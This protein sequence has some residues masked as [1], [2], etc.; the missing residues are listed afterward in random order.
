[1]NEDEQILLLASKENESEKQDMWYMDTGASNHMCGRKEIFIELD[2]S[3]SGQV[4]FGDNSKVP[5]KAKER[6]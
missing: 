4:S 1:M 2:E 5:V 3:I 6:F